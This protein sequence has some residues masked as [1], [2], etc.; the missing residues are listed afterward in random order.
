MKTNLTKLK[1][2]TIGFAVLE[3]ISTSNI[4]AA[5]HFGGIAM[6]ALLTVGL[7]NQNKWKLR[8]DKILTTLRIRK[9]PN[10]FVVPSPDKYNVN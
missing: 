4:S 9:K 5:A 3:A 7:F 6:G 8:W 10:L 2:L 1:I